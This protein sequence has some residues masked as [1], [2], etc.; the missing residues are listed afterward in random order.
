MLSFLQ[1]AMDLCDTTLAFFDEDDPR[2]SERAVIG[3][4]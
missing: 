2:K 3:C 4:K 1:E